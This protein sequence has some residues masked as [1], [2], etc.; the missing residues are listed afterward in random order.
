MIWLIW[1]RMGF[2]MG[3]CEHNDEPLGSIKSEWIF[4]PV[5]RLSTLRGGLSSM[6]FV[7]PLHNIC[8]KMKAYRMHQHFC[9]Q[10]KLYLIPQK[11]LITEKIYIQLKETYTYILNIWNSGSQNLVH[12]PL[13]GHEG[14]LWGVGSV[15]KK[16]NFNIKLNWITHFLLS[17]T[18]TKKVLWPC[19]KFLSKSI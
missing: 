1:F 14:V 11:H 5:E 15:N 19:C 3:S 9:V 13:R 16:V 17:Y 10:I 8:E 18:C 6:E 7:I 2:M 12:A 4:L